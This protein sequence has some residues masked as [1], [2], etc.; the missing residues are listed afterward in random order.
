MFVHPEHRSTKPR[1][2][3]SNPAGRT[4]T[5]KKRQ[6]WKPWPLYEAELARFALEIDA[7]GG[8]DACHPWQGKPDTH[9]YGRFNLRGGAYYLA[10]RLAL[11]LALGRQL[12]PNEDSRHSNACT[13]RLCCN[14]RHLQPGSKADNVADRVAA[15]RCAIA[16]RNAQTKLTREI[17]LDIFLRRSA[18]QSIASLARE[19]EVATATVRRIMSGAAWRHVT[20]VVSLVEGAV[21]SPRPSVPRRK[22]FDYRAAYLALGLTPEQ[23]TAVQARTRRLGRRIAS[24]E[25]SLQRA[26]E[27]LDVTSLVVPS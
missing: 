9:G 7:S 11:Q 20:G 23:V 1:V 21:M 4:T 19:H 12:Q 27:L 26:K 25:I 18:G 8:P 22:P 16:E 15:G 2:A 5:R 3:G 17:A 10:H 6:N 24:G 13:T 14:Q